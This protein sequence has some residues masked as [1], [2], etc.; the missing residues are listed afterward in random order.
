MTSTPAHT[1]LP[2]EHMHTVESVYQFTNQLHSS[3]T[4]VFIRMSDSVY[5]SIYTYTVFHYNT[6]PVF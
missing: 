3:M 1:L 2:D 5:M 4:D 6:P